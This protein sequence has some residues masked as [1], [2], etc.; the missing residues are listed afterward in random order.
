MKSP[1][2]SRKRRGERGSPWRVPRKTG[3]FRVLPLWVSKVVCAPLYRLATIKKKFS[4]IP[5]TRRVHSSC[6][7]SAEGKAWVKSRYAI[8]TSLLCV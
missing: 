3:I 4:G 1:T 6:K 2:I 5:R 7:W 8:R